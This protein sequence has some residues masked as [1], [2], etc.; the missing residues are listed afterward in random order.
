MSSCREKNRR[1]EAGMSDGFAA[2]VFE[3]LS[4]VLKNYSFRINFH[5]KVKSS[6]VVIMSGSMNL[7]ADCCG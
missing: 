3:V 7:S 1:N 5:L 2:V 4:C 6:A